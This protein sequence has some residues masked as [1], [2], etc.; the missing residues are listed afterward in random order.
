MHRITHTQL[1]TSYS[2]KWKM[3]AYKDFHI[4]FCVS[5][6]KAFITYLV[7]KDKKY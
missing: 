7:L 4:L 1:E 2:L 3:N 5:V 6:I